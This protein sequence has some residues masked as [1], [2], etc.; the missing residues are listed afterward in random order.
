MVSSSSERALKLNNNDIYSYLAR[1]RSREEDADE[2]LTAEQRRSRQRPVLK[3]PEHD[4]PLNTTENP[5]AVS[6]PARL[7]RTTGRKDHGIQRRILESSESPVNQV[8]G[9]GVDVGWTELPMKR[10]AKSMEGWRRSGDSWGTPSYGRPHGI[11]LFAV[12]STG[13]A[14]ILTGVKREPPRDGAGNGTA[15]T[16]RKTVTDTVEQTTLNISGYCTQNLTSWYPSRCRAVAT[17]KESATERVGY[18]SRGTRRTGATGTSAPK[19]PPKEGEIELEA[20]EY[21]GDNK[22]I[23]SVEKSPVKRTRKGKEDSDFSR[24]PWSKQATTK[25]KPEIDGKSQ[26]SEVTRTNNLAS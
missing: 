3:G 12:P 6:E 22:A 19:Q 10:K 11:G 9:D 21:T 4:K 5:D 1:P 8:A 15:V 20:M 18:P 25:T 17:E 13:T 23:R 26:A 16:G 14:V 24:S 2:Q 7:G